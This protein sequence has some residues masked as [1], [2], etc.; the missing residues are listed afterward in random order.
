MRPRRIL[1]RSLPSLA[2]VALIAAGCGSGTRSEPRL[3]QAAAQQLLAK[4]RAVEAALAEGDG[5]AA[6]IALGALQQ[7]SITLINA[8]RV[9]A[10]FQEELQTAVGDLTSRPMPA[11]A[12]PT[13]PQ[14]AAKPETAG[15]DNGH[16]RRGKGHHRKQGHHR[17][18]EK[19]D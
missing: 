12:P 19:D 5:C 15:D 7:T 17:K 11:C 4:T 6:G 3:P 10:A 16:G 1:T 14:P 18:R 2:L 13:P 9:P 8:G